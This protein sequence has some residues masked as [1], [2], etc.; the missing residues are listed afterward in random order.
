MQYTDVER[1]R[2]PRY[3]LEARVVLHREGAEPV[4]GQAVNI[5]SSGMLVHLAAPV[6]FAPGDAVTVELELPPN[7]DKPFSRWGIGSVVR[8]DEQ[9]SAIEL[10][11]GSFI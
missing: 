6:A 2:A 8:V 11:A 10:R 3:P 7:F 1:R 4:Y 9:Q 5:S